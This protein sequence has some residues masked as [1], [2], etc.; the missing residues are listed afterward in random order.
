[1]GS[2][3]SSTT[4]CPECP[5]FRSI[6]LLHA[7][8]GSPWRARRSTA[9]VLHTPPMSAS[10]RVVYATG[11]PLLPRREFF[12]CSSRGRLNL[13]YWAGE[14]RPRSLALSLAHRASAAV[15][16]DDIPAGFRGRGATRAAPQHAGASDNHG[17]NS[18]RF[19]RRIPFHGRAALHHG[20]VA[21]RAHPATRKGRAVADGGCAFLRA[22]RVARRW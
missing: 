11:R 8:G 4:S 7:A 6:S 10:G 20:R 22:L 19:S 16:H 13:G 3:Q 5:P 15:I 1:M 14:A 21:R 9:R 2:L 12:Y 17:P 18:T